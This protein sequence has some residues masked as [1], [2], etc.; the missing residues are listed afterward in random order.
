[1]VAAAGGWS[2]APSPLPARLCPDEASHIWQATRCDARSIQVPIAG[3]L[4]T[5]TSSANGQRVRKRQPDGG[6]M[7]L[8]G[9]PVS[10]ASS[11]RSLGSMLRREL[12]SALV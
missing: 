1:M 2:D 4:R 5:H 7:G 6:L 11:T 9:S 8:G 12:K 3:I 10:G